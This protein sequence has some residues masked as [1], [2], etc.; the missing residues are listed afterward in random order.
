MNYTFFSF[1]YLLPLYLNS[2]HYHVWCLFFYKSAKSCFYDA[3]IVFQCQSYIY[4]TKNFKAFFCKVN[5]YVRLFFYFVCER[6]PNYFTKKN[7]NTRTT[8]L[9]HHINDFWYHIIVIISHK[10]VQL[11]TSSLTSH[12]FIINVPTKKVWKRWMMKIYF[13][14]LPNNLFLT[15]TVWQF[16]KDRSRFLFSIPLI[17]ILSV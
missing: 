3:N 17:F 12:A 4:G 11:N 16:F 6:P 8:K 10:I 2:I 15:K 7:W 9:I 5:I 13:F 14:I 1:S